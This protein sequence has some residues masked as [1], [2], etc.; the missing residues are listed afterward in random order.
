MSAPAPAV[1]N[2]AAKVSA[3]CAAVLGGIFAVAAFGVMGGRAGLS[4]TIG[5]LIAVSNL[6][7]LRAIIRSMVVPPEGDAAEASE[8]DHRGNGR[9]GGAAWAIFAVLKIFVLF[10]GVWMLLARGLVDPIPLVVGYSVLP[11]GMTG[12]TLLSALRPRR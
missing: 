10:G 1:E 2:D 11:L 8:D 4:V 9:R 6:L 5:A 7:V 12:S 3:I